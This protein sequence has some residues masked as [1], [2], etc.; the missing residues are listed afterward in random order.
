MQLFLSIA[1][2]FLSPYAFGG[3]DEIANL[4]TQHFYL[5]ITD[6]GCGPETVIRFT[7]TILKDGSPD[8]DTMQTVPFYKECSMSKT[9]QGFSCNQE[10]HSPLAG[11]AYKVV[12]GGKPMCRADPGYRYVCI[13]GCIKGAPKYL[14]MIHE[15]DEG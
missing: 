10:G 11:A 13:R 8:W 1:L 9:F 4:R 5:E 6:D 7:R 14:N 15:C 2:V 12:K 3:C